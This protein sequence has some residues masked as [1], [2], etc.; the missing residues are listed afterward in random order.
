MS[1]LQVSFTNADGT[2]AEKGA[3]Y[4]RFGPEW[5]P[6]G[7]IVEAGVSEV[8]IQRVNDDGFLVQ[9][10]MRVGVGGERLVP[11]DL[12]KAAIIPTIFRA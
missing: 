9:K 6:Q 11:C 4:V 1:W 3:Y 2:K 12:D 7:A 8:P 5:L 10:G